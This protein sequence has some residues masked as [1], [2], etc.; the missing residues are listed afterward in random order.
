MLA[1]PG[2]L[3]KAAGARIGPGIVRQAEN[4][5]GGGLKEQR[6][7]HKRRERKLALAGF[8]LR[9]GALA[10]VQKICDGGL[11]QVVIFA[12]IAETKILVFHTVYSISE[13]YLKLEIL[14]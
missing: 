1:L 8:I 10:H 9:I 6:K 12:D 4:I 11:R 14:K 5:I 2:F 7:L 3:H 13:V